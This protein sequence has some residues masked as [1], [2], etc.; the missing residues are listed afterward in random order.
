MYL[1]VPNVSADAEDAT[2]CR[3]PGNSKLKQH[4]EEL[5]VASNAG[6]DSACRRGE[7]G[8]AMDEGSEHPTGPE[9]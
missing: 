1:K 3:N 9:E 5:L 2:E 7:T 6:I 4:S 8:K